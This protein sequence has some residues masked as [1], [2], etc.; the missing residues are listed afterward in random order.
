MTAG[1]SRHQALRRLGGALGLALLGIGCAAPRAPVSKVNHNGR[2]LAHEGSR[3][4]LKAALD[5]NDGYSTLKAV[6]R[7][8]LEYGPMLWNAARMSVRMCSATGRV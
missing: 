4:L 2:A 7:V 8:A 1:S 3:A 6:H 5:A